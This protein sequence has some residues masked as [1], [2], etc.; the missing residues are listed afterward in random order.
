MGRPKLIDEDTITTK[1][2]LYLKARQALAANQGITIEFA[3][4]LLGIGRTTARL[5][6]AQ[7]AWG[8]KR[9]GK[10]HRYEFD[11]YEIRREIGLG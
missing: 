6:A 11:P 9:V 10:N 2:P 5:R 1:N 4:A 8:V 3:A 7:G